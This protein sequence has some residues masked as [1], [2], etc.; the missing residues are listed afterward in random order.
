LPAL[1]LAGSFAGRCEEHSDGSL[2]NQM[3][4]YRSRDFDGH[5]HSAVVWNSS[6]EFLAYTR[7]PVCQI[8]HEW[9]KKDVSLSEISVQAA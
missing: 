8:N 6:G 4:G 7:C 2:D 3:P 1:T 5:S 9:S